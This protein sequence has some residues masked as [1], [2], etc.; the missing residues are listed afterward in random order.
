MHDPI[1]NE[2]LFE[3]MKAF[4]SAALPPSL[5]SPNMK[6]RANGT[7]AC[8]LPSLFCRPASLPQSSMA[9]RLRILSGMSR[10]CRSSVPVHRRSPRC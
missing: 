7:S 3:I 5:R 9:Q 4:G 2:L 6:P 8:S 1:T 10:H